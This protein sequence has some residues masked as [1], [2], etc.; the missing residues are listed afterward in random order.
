MNAYL[1]CYGLN[2]EMEQDEGVWWWNEARGQGFLWGKDGTDTC[3]KRVNQVDGWL[4]AMTVQQS[5]HEHSSFKQQIQGISQCFRIR[6]LGEAWQRVS[7]WG[8]SWSSSQAVCRNC[9]SCGSTGPEEPAFQPSSWFWP[10]SSLLSH[11]L[12]DVTLR[13]D[14]PSLCFVLHTSCC[15]PLLTPSLPSSFL[16]SSHCPFHLSFLE[17]RLLFGS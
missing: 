7:A 2:R 8:S 15:L 12:P 17:G 13:R 9:T 16:P 1:G 10:H 11:R 4:L 14:L 5:I 6:N 3:M